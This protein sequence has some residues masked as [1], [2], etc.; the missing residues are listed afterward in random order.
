MERV[1]ALLEKEWGEAA[2][3]GMLRFTSILLTVLFTGLPLVFL[4]IGR[5]AARGVR[6]GQD[7]TRGMPPGALALLSHAH[8]TGPELIQAFLGSQF[9]PFFLLAPAIIPV[10]IA[11][12]SIIGEKRDRSLEPLLATPISVPELLLGKMAAAAL[13]GILAGWISFALYALGARPL[14]ISDA[15]YSVLLGPARLLGIGLVGPLLAVLTALSGLM[16]S[17][18]ASDPRSAQAIGGLVVLPVI[19]LVPGQLAGFVTLNLATV[20]L[21]VLALLLLNGVLLYFA[22][23]LFQRETILTRWR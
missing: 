6:P 17:S 13:P 11:T 10:Y 20:L 16:V 8:L 14:A 2:K 22:A 1:R 15:V 19:G 4:F 18:R 9:I 21:T 12:H 3:D 7:I 5:M 23:A